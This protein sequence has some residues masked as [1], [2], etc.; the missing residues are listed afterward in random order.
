MGGREEGGL[1]GVVEG[2]LPVL[3]FIICKTGLGLGYWSVV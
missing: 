3:W 1:E 2:V